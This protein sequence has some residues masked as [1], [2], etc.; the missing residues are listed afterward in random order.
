[1]FPLV[2]QTPFIASKNGLGPQPKTKYIVNS[3]LL[4]DLI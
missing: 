4:K 2:P 1:M 3:K